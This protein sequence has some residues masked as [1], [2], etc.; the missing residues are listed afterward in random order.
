[1]HQLL[2]LI[3]WIISF[4]LILYSEQLFKW[5]RIVFWAASR[6]S[7]LKR[8]VE[9]M[10]NNNQFTIALYLIEDKSRI[11]TCQYDRGPSHGLVTHQT[12]SDRDTF[13]SNDSS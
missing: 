7:S 2:T 13:E 9:K 8:S 12:V 3:C 4:S 10:K 11:E 1:M 5:S 6:S